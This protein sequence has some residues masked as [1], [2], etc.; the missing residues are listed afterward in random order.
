M[1]Y[2]CKRHRD[3]TVYQWEGPQEDPDFW[4]HHEKKHKGME[5]LMGRA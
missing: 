2:Y 3:K 5:R 1:M 4:A